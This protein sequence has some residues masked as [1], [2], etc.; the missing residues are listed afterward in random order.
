VL[1]G[2]K[3]NSYRNLQLAIGP[4]QA[5]IFYTDGLVEARNEAGQELGYDGFYSMVADSY[6][7]DAARYHERIMRAWSAWLG[8]SEAGDDLTM[9]VMVRNN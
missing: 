9:I 5:M 7:V 1:G 3:K 8:S 2:F 4:G 6:H